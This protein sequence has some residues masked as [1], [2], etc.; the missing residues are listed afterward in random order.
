MQ[1]TVLELYSSFSH[2]SFSL[3]FIYNFLVHLDQKYDQLVID[4]IFLVQL[5]DYLLVL[6][7][8]F[9]MVYFFWVDHSY[10]FGVKLI[11]VSLS[12]TINSY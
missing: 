6:I 1:H 7:S 5:K 9:S 2:I 12:M 11:P 3:R 8:S 10:L 4:S